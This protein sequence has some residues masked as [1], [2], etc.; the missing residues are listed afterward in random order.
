MT[1]VFRFLMIQMF[2]ED[3]NSIPEK[4]FSGRMGKTRKNKE[5]APAT[6]PEKLGQRRIALVR[7]A[8]LIAATLAFYLPA[9]NAGFIWDDD[10]YVTQNETLRSLNGLARIWFDIGATPQ[11]YPLVHT[12]F[13]IEYHLWGLHPSGYHI[14]NVI[15]HILNALFI[16][17]ILRKLDLRSAWFAAM[18]FA[19]HPVHVESVAWITE[20]KN[21]LSGFYYLAS[22]LSYLYFAGLKGE[23]TPPLKSSK[24][25]PPSLRKNKF[26]VLSLVLYLCA[27]LSKTVAASLPAAIL[28]ILWWKKNKIRIKD[29]LPL[30]PF[31]AVGLALGLVTVWMERSHVGAIGA[32]W[33]LSFMD[34]CLIAGRALCFYASK[35]LVPRNL[36]FIYPRW[37]MKSMGGLYFIPLGILSIVFILFL[38]RQKIGKGVLAAIL[39]FIITL[40]PALGF[41]NIYPMLFSFVA[42]HFQYLASIGLIAFFA[43]LLYK[44]CAGL[45]VNLKYPVFGAIFLI[46]GVLTWKQTLIYQNAEILW[47]DT[48]KKN[49]SSWMP[50]QNLGMILAEQGKLEEAIIHYKTSLDLKPDDPV[51]HYNMGSVL[52]EIGEYEK[53]LREYREAIR[54]KPDFPDAHSNL[55]A[56]LIILG[57][58]E[59]A[60]RSLEKALELHPEHFKA[61]DNMG[62]LLSKQGKIDE[63]MACYQKAISIE[64]DYDKAYYNLA[65][66]FIRKNDPA[67]AAEY[68]LKAIEV[69]PVF[70]EAY[71]SLGLTLASINDI[72][73]AIRTFSRLLE[74]DPNHEDARRLLNQM[75]QQKDREHG[76]NR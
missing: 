9:F 69:N 3:E 48:L 50:H 62:V 7:L 64:P 53:A 39:F 68:Y 33:N 72:E 44:A 45:N 65:V 23:G 67:K 26:Y 29:I 4:R 31:F 56:D 54:L 35:I 60:R 73:G 20:R 17:M 61:L 47:R 59:E 75:R 13:W 22:I 32:E 57:N 8:L 28:V 70:V 30:V 25:E 1:Y 41:F 46:L 16:W 12:S 38:K 52:E 43:A 34:R 42:D 55:G 14:T 18:I 66:A 51:S 15:L 19:L 36:S 71:Y 21:A 2:R 10:D 49:P 5:K 37:D 63:A 6:S 40:F 27:L 76:G 74:I 58:F 11:Y 24:D